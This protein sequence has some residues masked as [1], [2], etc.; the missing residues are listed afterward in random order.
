[1]GRLMVPI[2]SESFHSQIIDIT[3]ALKMCA[4]KSS[5]SE[6]LLPMSP[7]LDSA[8]CVWSYLTFSGICKLRLKPTTEKQMHLSFASEKVMILQTSQMC[9]KRY[10][11]LT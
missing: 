5:K 10:T 11:G 4:S 2:S 9:A 6:G 1:M 8:V 3:S 7:G